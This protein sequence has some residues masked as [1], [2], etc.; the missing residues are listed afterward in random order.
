[1]GI[2]ILIVVCMSNI[3]VDIILLLSDLT[4]LRE[5]KKK[6]KQKKKFVKVLKDRTNNIQKEYN[7]NKE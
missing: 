6:Q 1:M 7:Y 2:E 4:V 5:C 3:I